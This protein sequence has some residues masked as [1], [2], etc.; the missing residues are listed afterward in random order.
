MEIA[1]KVAVVTGAARGIGLALAKRLKAEGASG[2][3]LADVEAQV[4]EAAA[5]LNA[6][7]V[8]ADLR[9]AS[10]VERMI[11]M[12]EREFGRVDIV[13]SNAGIFR[14]DGAPDQPWNATVGSAADWQASWDINVMAHIHAARAALPG[15]LKRGEGYFLHTASAAGLLS[16]IGSAIYST[17]K[18]AAIGF[19]ESLAIAHG[20]AGIGVSVLC[21]QAV[22]TPML[23][24]G[25]ETSAAAGDGV[26]EPETVAECAMAGIRTG[27]FLILPH[28]EVSTY[29]KR[30]ADDHDRWL[31]GMQRLRTR[32]AERG[33]VA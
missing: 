27:Q 30:K 8:Q 9:Q 11:A 25:G 23:G 17:T 3:L 5:D 26:I 16:Q 22:R 29:W 31:R 14:L 20:D 6:I 33:N 32:L 7:A 4:S 18:H 24:S 2:L 21:P 15:M 12:A 28:A 10:E 1:G 13:C 19:A